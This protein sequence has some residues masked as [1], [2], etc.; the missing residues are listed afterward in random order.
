VKFT[1]KGGI[2]LSAQEI[3]DDVEII[4]SDTGIGIKEADLPKLLEAFERL[5]SHLRI[6]AGG[7]GLGLYLTRKICTTLLQGEV[8]VKSTHGKGSVF[9][10]RIRRRLEKS[11]EHS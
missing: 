5:E 7:T 10:L 6:K 2:T 9:S 11:N 3:G 1:E 8:S 4:V